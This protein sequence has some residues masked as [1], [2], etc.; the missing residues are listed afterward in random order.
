MQNLA[1]GEISTVPSFPIAVC[2]PPNP[3]TD[4][5]NGLQIYFAFLSVPSEVK[6]GIAM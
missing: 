3:L 1:E 5:P 4:N 6:F 2:S